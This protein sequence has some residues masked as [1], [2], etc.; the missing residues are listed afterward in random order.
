MVKRL[1]DLSKYESIPVRRVYIPK[2][3]STDKRPLGIPTMYDRAVQTLMYYALLPIAEY[4]A[5]PRSFGFR[6]YRSA[7]DAIQY[8]HFVIAKKQYCWVYEADI[9]KCF[10]RISHE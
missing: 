1:R 9:E 6:P 5:D 8:I 2:P 4:R 7:K 3:G 10:D